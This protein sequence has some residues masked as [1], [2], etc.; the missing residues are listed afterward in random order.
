L[1]TKPLACPTCA[2]RYPLEE[3]F[4]ARCR[5]PLVYIGAEPLDTPASDAHGKA[6]KINP[7]YTEGELVRVAGGRNQAEAEFIQGLLLEEGV[8]SILRRSAGFDV[9][10]FLAA[11]PRDVMVPQAGAETAHEVL[12]TADMAPPAGPPYRPRPLLLLAA[13]GAGGALTALIAWALLQ[14]G[15]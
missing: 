3:R 14:V 7:A 9:P 4:C 2:L 1:R 11:G 12:L 15:T 6:R 13:I 8:P 5:M 10:D